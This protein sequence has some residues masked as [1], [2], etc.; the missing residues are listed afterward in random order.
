MAK[1]TATKLAVV[2][3]ASESRIERAATELDQVRRQIADLVEKKE[4]LAARLLLMTKQE[5]EPDAE[6]KVRYETDLHK[7]VIIPGTNVYIHPKK[8]TLALTAQ[9]ITPKVQR[10][11][12]AACV[13]ETEYEY[14]GVYAKKEKGQ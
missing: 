4:A 13:Q 1:S 11:I 7:F 9:G 5:G 12:R 10:A 8:L 6:G 3:P 2:H 14:V